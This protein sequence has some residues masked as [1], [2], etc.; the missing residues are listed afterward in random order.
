LPWKGFFF[1][2]GGAFFSFFFVDIPFH[3]ERL[4]MSQAQGIEEEAVKG[5]EKRD[6]QGKAPPYP[7]RALFLPGFF[8]YDRSHVP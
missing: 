2:P 5:V 1:G 6:E 4:K 7:L 8:L 3:N